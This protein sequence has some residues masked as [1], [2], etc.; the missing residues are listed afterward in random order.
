MEDRG[1]DG[2]AGGQFL[3][4]LF[5]ALE[6][7]E[8][9]SAGVVQFLKDKGLATDDELASYLEAAAGASEVRWRAARLRMD[10]LFAAAIKDAEE[11]FA[12]KVEER[13]ESAAQK[14]Q[15]SREVPENR[16]GETNAVSKE[17]ASRAPEA[18]DVKNEEV[19]SEETETGR[20]VAKQVKESQGADRET[21]EV[22]QDNSPVNAGSDRD[23]QTN[24]REENPGSKAA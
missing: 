24:S 7:L 12:W 23:S 19:K 5:S 15:E 11:D 2:K 3:D 18:E 4:E 14:P 9:Q 20:K 17:A 21:T 10:A 6:N 1:V 13:K 16:K 22:R 8:T